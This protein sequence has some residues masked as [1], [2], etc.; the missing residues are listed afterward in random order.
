MSMRRADANDELVGRN[1]RL[2]RLSRGLSQSALADA[3][4]VTF[5]QVQKYEKGT[6]R[7]GSGRLVRIAAA[8]DV[9]VMTLLHEVA[10]AERKAAPT[11]RKAAPPSPLT[12]LA[13]PLPLRLVQAFAQ[14]EDR[15]VRRSLM[16]LTE[17]IARLARGRGENGSRPE[18]AT[19][20]RRTVGS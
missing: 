17:G 10:P 7:V 15:S 12:L 4:G 1:I 19:G 11:E 18:R 8:L 3:I 9:P 6:N 20:R 2:Q 13:H 14:I 16:T 5:Q